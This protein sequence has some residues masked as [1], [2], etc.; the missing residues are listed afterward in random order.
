MTDASSRASTRLLEILA[1]KIAAETGVGEE[2]ARELAASAL[3]SPTV[4][5]SA[6]IVLLDSEG[7][8]A[9]RIPFALL[10]EAF[11]DLDDEE[12]ART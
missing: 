6:P 7:R 12:D 11:D 4:D 8:E 10:E 2:L 3:S 9:A 5:E 1:E